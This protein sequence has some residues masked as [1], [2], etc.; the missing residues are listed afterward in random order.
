MNTVI[1]VMVAHATEGR[2]FGTESFDT[3]KNCLFCNVSWHSFASCPKLW[4]PDVVQ[5]AYIQLFILQPSSDD[6]VGFSKIYVSLGVGIQQDFIDTV[7]YEKIS[8]RV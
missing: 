5:K 7:R 1:P 8:E 3:T 2:P 6:K 4:N